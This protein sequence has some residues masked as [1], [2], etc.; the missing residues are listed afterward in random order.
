MLNPTSKSR[1]TSPR[2]GEADTDANIEDIDNPII[3]EEKEG[4]KFKPERHHYKWTKI[5]LPIEK[6]IR[7]RDA[8]PIFTN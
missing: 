6:Q 2:S 3:E 1:I 4:L 5:R 7:S 8:T